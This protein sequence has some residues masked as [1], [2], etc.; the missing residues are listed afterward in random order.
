MSDAKPAMVPPATAAAH[1]QELRAILDAAGAGIAVL[2]AATGRV[3]EVNAVLC[4]ITGFDADAL[5]ARRLDDLLDPEGPVMKRGPRR[6]V[7]WVRADGGRVSVDLSEARV[8]G[9]NAMPDRVVV[10]ALEVDAPAPADDRPPGNS[11][12][13]FDGLIRSNPFG[14]YVVD[15]DFR[16]AHVSRGATKVFEN[17]RPL[18]GRDFAEVLRVIWQ[19]P[20]ASEAIGRF[21]HTLDT[22]EPF[23]SPSTVEQRADIAETEAYDWRIERIAMPDGRPGV[24]CYFYDLSER[25]RWAAQV[26]A[27]ERRL[28]QVIDS[29]FAFVGVLDPDGTLV[30]ANRAPIDAAGL[31]REDVIGRPFWDCAWW[32][33]DPAVRERLHAAYLRARAGETVRYDETIRVAGDGRIVIDFMLQPVFEDGDLRCLIPSGV[34]VTARH[35]AEAMLRE[36]DERKDRFLATLSHELRNPLAPIRQAAQLLGRAAVDADTLAWARQVIQRQVGHMA[37]L[38]DDLL[39]IARITQGKLALRRERVTLASVVDTAIEA[40]RPLI[41]RKRHRLSLHLPARGCELDADPVRLSQVLSNLLTNAAKYTDHDGD[42]GVTAEVQGRVLRMSVRDSG[43][44]L[45][46]AARERLFTMFT[47]LDGGAARSEGGL[48]IGLALAQGLVALHGGTIAAHSDGRGRG[49][50]FVV[51]VP[52]VVEGAVEGDAEPTSAAASSVAAVRVLVADDN[53]DAGATLAT[54]LQ[55]EGHDVRLV[56]DGRAAVEA[57]QAFA[58]QLALLDIGMPQLDGYAAARAMRALPNCAGTLLVALTGWGQEEDKRRAREAGFDHHLTKPADYERVLELVA[59]AA[60]RAAATGS[61]P[62]AAAR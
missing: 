48:G 59:E 50:C 35:A 54:L 3:F 37:L 33:H 44:G 17:V 32:T 1:A 21:R 13:T 31:V 53:V 14:V 7:R 51:E 25:Q 57:A 58:P 41:E 12:D 42:I 15:S 45:E 38:L 28:R 4:A 46:P 29:M 40:A 18:I 23:G 47:Q 22:G 11:A 49:S 10:T 2:D 5:R 16:L 43:I 55:L 27:S 6:R 62:A 56:G 39:D 60:G 61:A 9:R 20:F 26:V 24:V 8:P 19:E 34:D 52:V 30:E 36:A